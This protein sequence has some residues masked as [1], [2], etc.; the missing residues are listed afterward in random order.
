MDIRKLERRE[1]IGFSELSKTF[2]NTTL[3]PYAQDF[4][5]YREN[6]TTFDTIPQYS[7]GISVFQCQNTCNL[8]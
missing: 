5:H 1:I 6:W 4:N 2:F 7:K 8:V 3:P